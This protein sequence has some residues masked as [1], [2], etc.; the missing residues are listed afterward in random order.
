MKGDLKHDIL[1]KYFAG[2]LSKKEEAK[3]RLWL[4]ESSEHQEEFEQLRNL[5]L[6]SSDLKGLF[7][8]KLGWVDMK[9]RIKKDSSS[10]IFTFTRVAA[11]I[12]ILFVSVLIYY[13]V[14]RTD[15][16]QMFYASTNGE[17]QE[18]L[19]PDG[20]VTTLNTGSSL[21]L[22]SDFGKTDRAVELSG[23]AYFDVV[24][25]EDKV[26]QVFVGKIT[27]SVLGTQFNVNATD[28][29]TVIN[30]FEGKVRVETADQSLDLQI[31]EALQ[32][33]RTG[34]MSTKLPSEAND[35]FWK[36]GDLIFDSMPLADALLT[37]GQKYEK[38][39]HLDVPNPEN[40]ELTTSFEDAELSDILE[41][42]ALTYNLEISETQQ[43]IRLTGPGCE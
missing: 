22:A 41:V 31:G 24:R 27:I 3:V 40:C 9:E 32:I 23:E 18:E 33:D 36:T 20:T 28:S 26:F 12:A 1:A 38:V 34:K 5:M 30:V 43:V 4:E 10:Q 8:S 11:S 42:I 6:K 29:I 2:E 35:L 39:I 13:L 37:I 7:D 16:A 14:I 17:V 15:E 21:K 25:D 19:L